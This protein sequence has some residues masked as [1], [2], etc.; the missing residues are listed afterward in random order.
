MKEIASLISRAVRDDDGSA[1]GE[2]RARVT[3][4]TAAH[5]AYPGSGPGS[6]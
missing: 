4:L 3:T 5:P 2:L 6:R 1:A